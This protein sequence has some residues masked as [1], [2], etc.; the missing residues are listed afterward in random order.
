MGNDSN[1][2]KIFRILMYQVKALL[3]KGKGIKNGLFIY[4]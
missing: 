1:T 4:R 3:Q 2:S